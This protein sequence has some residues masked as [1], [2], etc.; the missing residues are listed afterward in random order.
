MG[1]GWTLDQKVWII[2]FD[3]FSNMDRIQRF[4]IPLNTYQKISY[5]LED[6]SF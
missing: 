2:G 3:G 1:M 6:W 4:P 5:E